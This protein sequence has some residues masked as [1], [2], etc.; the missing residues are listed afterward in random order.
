MG[1]VEGWG[2]NQITFIDIKDQKKRKFDNLAIENEILG[3]LFKYIKPELETEVKVQK[4]E[5]DVNIT[6]GPRLDIETKGSF[7]DETI[8]ES[9]KISQ[10]N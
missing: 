9:N 4:Q 1:A 3:Q 5:K 10:E 8:P 7:N 2:E 6:K